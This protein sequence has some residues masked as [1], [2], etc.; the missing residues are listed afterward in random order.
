MTCHT[1]E[2]IHENLDPTES[3]ASV[4]VSRDRVLFES[5]FC[6]QKGGNMPVVLWKISVQ[7]TACNLLEPRTLAKTDSCTQ[8]M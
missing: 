5:E 3:V 4:V 8:C 1:E 7:I 2:S 6:S